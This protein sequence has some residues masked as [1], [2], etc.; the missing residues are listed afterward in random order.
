MGRKGGEEGREGREGGR[1][2]EKRRN[3]E[4]EGERRKRKGGETART[5]YGYHY[6]TYLISFLFLF[7]KVL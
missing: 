3:G 7:R 4:R 2:G 1:E 5:L 6:I